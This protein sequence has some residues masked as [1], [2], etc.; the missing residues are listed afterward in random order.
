MRTVAPSSLS[1]SRHAGRNVTQRRGR[2]RGRRALQ[3]RDV[4]RSIRTVGDNEMCLFKNN[5]DNGNVQAQ[6]RVGCLSRVL[7]SYDGHENV[8][9][10]H[11]YTYI[12]RSVRFRL[13]DPTTFT[14]FVSFSSTTEHT[15]YDVFTYPSSTTS[16]AATNSATETRTSGTVKD[17][18]A[19][20][21]GRSLG[22][23]TIH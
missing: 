8:I 22:R 20:A 4:L 10:R 11:G 18:A 9:Y 19:A 6:Y 14:I 21:D 3:S 2:G 7:T 12:Y 13:W 5:V 17:L 16:A 15:P 23:R 1:G